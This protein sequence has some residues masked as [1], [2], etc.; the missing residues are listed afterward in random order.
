MKRPI[1]ATQ[2]RYPQRLN[3]EKNELTYSYSLEDI[4]SLDGSFGG[5]AIAK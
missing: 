1:Y 4:E 2:Q 5:P 3:R